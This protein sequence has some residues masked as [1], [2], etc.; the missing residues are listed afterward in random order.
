MTKD[1]KKKHQ[2]KMNNVFVYGFFVVKMSEA[3]Q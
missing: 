3:L 2:S 1:E